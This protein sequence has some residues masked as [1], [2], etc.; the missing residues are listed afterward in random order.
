MAIRHT[1]FEANHAREKVADYTKLADGTWAVEVR[2]LKLRATAPTPTDR[3]FDSSRSLT[4][5]S[6]RGSSE[7]RTVNRR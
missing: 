4:N 5:A 6:R 2:A 3:K 7:L 1:L